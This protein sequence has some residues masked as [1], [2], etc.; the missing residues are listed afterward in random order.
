M[1]GLVKE[2][3]G[4]NSLL[5]KQVAEKECANDEVVIEVKYTGICGTDLHIKKDEYPA[6]YPVVLGH[7][8]SGK[9]LEIGSEV[10]GY[11]PGDRV[12]SLT[13]AVTCKKCEYCQQGLLML[14]PYRKS[15]GSGVD[16]AFAPKLTI[17]ASL[18]YQIPENISYEEAALSEPLACVVRC[19]IE[20]TSVK[21]GQ[22]AIISGPG[23]IG[24]LTMQ[25]AKAH[26]AHVV[27]LGT[28]N[29]LARL[30]LADQLGADETIVVNSEEG[31][32]RLRDLKNNANVAFECSGVE[33]S[34]VNCLELLKKQGHYT[35]V[36]LFGAP[37]KFDFD[38]ALMKEIT[39]TNG[40]ASEPTSW[41]IALRLM[42]TR[43]VQLKPLISDIFS[44]DEWEKGFQKAESKEGLKVLLTPNK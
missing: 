19:V 21:A 31:K 36:G 28:T 29:D 8:F 9:I 13:A 22:L 6:N 11:Q 23:A 35:Q 38:L 44:L 30:V 16:G 40:F 26:G 34:A 1:L 20:R 18:L 25:V 39:I 4:E 17:P 41:R 5:L 37:I 33:A 15:I 24:L 32:Q 2:K 7:E 3:K 14:C 42:E 10:K 27:V 12:V 43:Q